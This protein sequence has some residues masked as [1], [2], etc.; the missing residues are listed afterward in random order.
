MGDVGPALGKGSAQD[1]AVET[2]HETRALPAA[3]VHGRRDA[4][5]AVIAGD[6]GRRALDIRKV[7]PPH[8]RAVAEDPEVVTRV[9]H[10]GACSG[11]GL[12]GGR[13]I[14]PGLGAS[15]I[16]APVE[17]SRGP[18]ILAGL[19]DAAAD[20]AGLGEKIEQRFAIALGMAGDGQIW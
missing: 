7:G 9:A 11:L 16:A 8:Q 1:V 17:G 19:D 15:R 14:I 13:A 2:E 12:G 5:G 10:G 3:T 4:E 6:G 18:G 20:L